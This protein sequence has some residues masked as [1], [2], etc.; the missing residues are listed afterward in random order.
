MIP[1]FLQHLST[2]TVCVLNVP[3]SRQLSPTNSHPLKLTKARVPPGV[4]TVES[5]YL[6]SAAAAAV[7]SASAALSAAREREE[8]KMLGPNGQ[9]ADA[10]NNELTEIEEVRRSVV[11]RSH[12]RTAKMV[13]SCSTKH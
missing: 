9:W 3:P 4:N 6:K 5:R 10:W 12:Y 2:P 8:L 11:Q 1:G 13:Q 7:K